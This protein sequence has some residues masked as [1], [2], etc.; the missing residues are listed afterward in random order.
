MRARIGCFEVPSEAVSKI[1][2]V[3]YDYK[4]WLRFFGVLP[5]LCSYASFRS[6][7]ATAQNSYVVSSF[8][9][10]VASLLFRSSP[11]I[12]SYTLSFLT[13]N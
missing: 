2:Q 3:R 12:L 9:L 5:R 1:L 11:T 13:V 8:V 6:P 7:S 10:K 4:R